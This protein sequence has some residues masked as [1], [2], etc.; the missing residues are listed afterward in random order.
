MTDPAAFRAQFPVLAGLAYLNAG[1]EGPVPR[2]AAEAVQARVRLDLTDGRVGRPYF[3]TVLE[4]ASTTRAGYAQVL[5]A[6]PGEVALT[7]STTDG[8]NSV[9]GGL[10]FAPGDE[11]LTSDEEHPGL[12]APLRL[13]RIRQGVSVRAVPFERLSEALEPRTRLIAC[14]HVSW[15]SGR[16]ADVPALVAGGVP[17]LLDGAQ[18]LGAIPVDV[19]ALGIDFYAASG[20][21]WLCGPEGSGCLYVRPDRLAELEPPWPGYMTLA[22]DKGLNSELAEGTARLDLGFPP[23]IR[24]AWARA[25]LDVLAAAGWPWVHERAA[26]LAQLL[27]DRLTERGIEVAPR[28]RTTLVSWPAR[29]WEA[30]VVRLASAGFVIRSISA[31]GLIRASVGAWS[32]EDEIERLAGTAAP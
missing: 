3:E 32:S 14:S 7:G 16:L 10:R 4:L 15:V 31:A 6:Q 2:A 21:K 29:D 18:A 11:I 12:L 25:S 27:A 17:V 30:E 19:H 23:A 13:A 24:S 9:L 1:T 22:G 26:S 5:G 28:G 20:Q 8:V